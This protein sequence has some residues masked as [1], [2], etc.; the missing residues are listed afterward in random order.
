MENSLKL[1]RVSE[2]ILELNGLEEGVIFNSKKK[3]S[4]HFETLDEVEEFV[5]YVNSIP[6][7][8]KEEEK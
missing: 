2:N 6:E 5:Y 1:K 4:I 7:Q 3:E 8:K